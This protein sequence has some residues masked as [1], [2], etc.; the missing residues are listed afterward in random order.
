MRKPGESGGYE[1]PPSPI[2]P[3]ELQKPKVNPPQ[4]GE[5]ESRK[6]Q[7][8]PRTA[9]QWLKLGIENGNYDSAIALIDEMIE[10]IPE[11]TEYATPQQEPE[12]DGW[13]ITEGDLDDRVGSAFIGDFDIRA[14]V[15]R[16]VA[17]RLR[18]RLRARVQPRRVEELRDDMGPTAVIDSRGR[19]WTKGKRS[20]RSAYAKEAF[21]SIS[22]LAERFG[23]LR[24]LCAITPTGDDRP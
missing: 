7:L 13:E 22:D 5:G 17:E 16:Q 1:G 6:V 19:V 20:F 4:K 14:Q 10:Q 18:D 12:G 2:P 9:L 3:T 23:P 15:A 11:G 21:L 8:G 24:T